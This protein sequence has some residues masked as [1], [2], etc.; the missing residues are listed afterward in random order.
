MVHP[1]SVCL[2][3]K[4]GMGNLLSDHAMNPYS[5]KCNLK[6]VVPLLVATEATHSHVVKDL[7]HLLR[8]NRLTSPCLQRP[9][10]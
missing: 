2:G 10:P 9:P 3:G 4:N 1:I 6:I 5:T 7:P 8:T